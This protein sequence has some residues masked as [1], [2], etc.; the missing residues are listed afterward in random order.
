MFLVHTHLIV[1]KGIL[2]SRYAWVLL[3]LRARFA[4]FASYDIGIPA[5][6]ILFIIFV[7]YKYSFVW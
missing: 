5:Y 7:C 2:D 6:V 3:A 4:I 1:L